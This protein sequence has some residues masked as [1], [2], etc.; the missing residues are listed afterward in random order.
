MNHRIPLAAAAGLLGTAAL[1][2]GAL[3]QAPAQ[4]TEERIRTAFAAADDNKDGV[5]NVDEMVGYSLY[6]FKRYDRNADG[7]LTPDELPKHDAARFKRADRD[8]DGRLS[9]GEVASE[10]VYEF[11]ATDTNRNGVI[12]LQEI[13]AYEAKMQGARK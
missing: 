11:F 9:H 2:A 8:G 7:F 3:A 12:T 6:M 1:M 13:L 4:S 5:I 10:K